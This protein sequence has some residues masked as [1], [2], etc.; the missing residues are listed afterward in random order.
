[1]QKIDIRA[2]TADICGR[3]TEI[4]AARAGDARTAI[5]IAGPPASGKSTLASRLAAH[6]GPCSCVI[7][8]DGFHLD[9][10]LLKQ[11][12]LLPVKGAPE[13]FDL[14]GF[15]GLVDALINKRTASF[16]TFDRD[17]DCTV[18]NGG[19]VCEGVTI[20][21]FEGNYLLFNEAGWSELAVKWDA[22]IWL[23]VAETVLEKRLVQRW[24]D[25]GLTEAEARQRAHSND[26]VNARRILS[27]ALPAD[28]VLRV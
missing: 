7:P 27:H 5:A 25:Q 21:L 17:S 6:L 2:P 14:Q 28:W 12:G 22:S 26:L 1:M 19:S 3:I 24:L 15:T 16:P 8:M 9:N 13:T 11:R 4:S 18:V 10:S 20:L 23:D